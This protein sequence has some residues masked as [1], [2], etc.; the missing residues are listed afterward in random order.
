MVQYG[1]RMAF[2]SRIQDVYNVYSMYTGNCEDLIKRTRP[3]SIRVSKL[4]WKLYDDLFTALDKEVLK[5]ILEGTIIAI[6]KQKLDDKLPC[7]ELLNARLA[8]AV[9][10]ATGNSQV[11]FN[12][13]VNINKAEANQ[14]VDVKIDLEPIIKIVKKLYELRT[15]LPPLQRKLV[16]ELHKRL[17]GVSN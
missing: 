3:L 2:E 7:K 13:N 1:D 4:V 17:K 15:P 14:K 16:E 10:K 11:S 8:Y 5:A 9:A 6:A 12:I